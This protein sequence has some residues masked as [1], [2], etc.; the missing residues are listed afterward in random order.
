MFRMFNLKRGAAVC[1]VSVLAAV[2]AYA[3][4][5]NGGSGS[6]NAGTGTTTGIT[7][8]QTTVIAGL[9]PGGPVQQLAG[10]F[11]NLNAGSVFVNQVNATFGAIPGGPLVDESHPC[12]SADYQLNGFPVTVG[13]EVP[14]GS[15]QGNWSGA[16][17]QMRN[18]GT[19]QDGCKDGTV[20]LVYTSN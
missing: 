17:I 1:A 4:W 13:A 15:A 20:N 16:S 12:T 9:Y 10:K 3:Y 18:T 7:V 11:N 14:T 8:T 2:G 19:N 6:G 5:T